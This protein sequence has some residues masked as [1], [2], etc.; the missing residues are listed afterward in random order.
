[1]SQ[2]WERYQQAKDPA[3][4]GA[5]AIGSP[6][7]PAQAAS[8]TAA[9]DKRDWVD[10]IKDYAKQKYD[11]ANDPKQYDE[12]AFGM[13]LHIGNPEGRA[14][15]KKF[16]DGASSILGYPFQFGDRIQD[17]GLDEKDTAD[18]VG[19]P[20]PYTNDKKVT[21]RQLENLIGNTLGAK[22]ASELTEFLG[23]KMFESSNKGIDAAVEIGK[24]KEGGV[25][26]VLRK[27][28]I[29]GGEESKLKQMDTLDREVFRP[30]QADVEAQATAAGGKP[31]ME[32]VVA[33]LQQHINQKKSQWD[34]AMTSDRTETIAKMQADL[35]ELRGMVP[36][37]SQPV[38][39]ASEPEVGYSANTAAREHQ[40]NPSHGPEGVNFT[41]SRPP[42]ETNTGA[43][44]NTEMQTPIDARGQAIPA[45]QEG[46]IVGP[47]DEIVSLPRQSKTVMT[48]ARPGPTLTQARELKTETGGDKSL[49]SRERKTSMQE[50]DK[51]KYGALQRAVEE[52]VDQGSPGQGAEYAKTNADWGRVLDA[53]PRAQLEA[54]R[55]ARKTSSTQVKGGL[56]AAGKGP[57]AAAM[58]AVRLLN[59]YGKSVGGYG[60]MTPEVATA[61]TA[62]GTKGL[63]PSE[64]G[65]S[66]ETNTQPWERYKK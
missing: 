32:K 61:T 60:L 51:K 50:W 43:A 63:I 48:K 11:E 56:L 12:K 23:N 58:E 47:D 24:G 30:H 39:V 28:G 14:A 35:E 33:E 54:M 37:A 44:V 9:D 38:T 16:I 53:K 17:M 42:V 40:L 26:P 7:A 46:A 20:I 1:M 27:Y 18:K 41:N 19:I 52:G 62:A 45:K 36:R 4:P 55:E 8:L 2:P 25:S 66:N 22:K 3:Q 64:E 57:A 5:A 6:A 65:G 13:P 15:G 59:K 21:V 29:R 34:N 31:D 49:W 10:K